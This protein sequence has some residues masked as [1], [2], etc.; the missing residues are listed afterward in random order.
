MRRLTI[1]SAALALALLAPASAHA[2]KRDAKYLWATVN[3]C[4]T[5]L[6]PN[7]IGVRGS[8]PGNGTRQRLFMRFEAQYFDTARRRWAPTGSS[9]RWMRVG[10]A[11]KRSTQAGFSFQF[12]QPPGG[13]KFRMRG[14]VDFQ[15]RGRRNGRPVVVRRK[16]RITR[17]GI[18]GVG[19]GDPRNTSL[20]TCTIR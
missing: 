5:Q 16:A 12:G 10:R 1:L 17:A 11:D 7:T 3:L 18:S 13:T 4:D 8:M 15:W 14:R 9:S 19:G 6:S 20:A 2:G